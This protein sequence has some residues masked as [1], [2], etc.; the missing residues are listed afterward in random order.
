M[1]KLVIFS[2]LIA[3]ESS[4]H[5]LNRLREKRIDQVHHFQFQSK[6][7]IYFQNIHLATYFFKI[8]PFN[9]LRNFFKLQNALLFTQIIIF[10]ESVF[11]KPT[12]NFV[13]E[14]HS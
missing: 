12:S 9:L 8:I 13:E 3:F 6:E 14:L 2:L 11:T 10:E 1:L 4:H 5:C 7:H